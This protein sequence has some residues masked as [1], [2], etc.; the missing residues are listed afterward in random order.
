MVM[1]FSGADGLTL[2]GKSS[3][4][5][6]YY[7]SRQWVQDVVLVLD[8]IEERVILHLDEQLYRFTGYSVH[9]G[10]GLILVRVFADMHSVQYS[11]L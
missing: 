1:C 4:L 5:C 2:P 10:N 7:Y 11:A 6:A 8:V 3:R 9:A